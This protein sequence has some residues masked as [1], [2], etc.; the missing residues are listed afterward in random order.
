MTR[1]GPGRPLRWMAALDKIRLTGPLRRDPA[2]AGSFYLRAACSFAFPVLEECPG[3]GVCVLLGG[4]AQSPR[5]HECVMMI[6]RQR[7]QGRMGFHVPDDGP[8]E[9]AG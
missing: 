1:Q 2:D 7:G 3:G 4:V 5:D 8:C 6:A 9:G